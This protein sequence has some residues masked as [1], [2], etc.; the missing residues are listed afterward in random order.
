[1]VVS[2][3]SASCSDC[4]SPT[5]PLNGYMNCDN[6]TFGAVCHYGCDLGF[7]LVGPQL[8][9]CTEIGAWSHPYT[10]CEMKGTFN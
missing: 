5:R 7:M 9:H 2:R 3:Y 4:M 8:S 10:Y 6:T 1:M